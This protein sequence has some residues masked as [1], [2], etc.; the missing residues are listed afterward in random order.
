MNAKPKPKAAVAD[1]SSLTPALESAA[2][3][4]TQDSLAQHQRLMDNYTEIARL[5]G[6]LAHEIKNPLS[7]I[8]LNME[9]LAEDFADSDSPRDKRALKKISIV[10]REC[11]RLQ[12]LLDDFLRF[13]KVRPLRPVNAD[14]NR[15]V[16][17][18]IDFFRPQAQEAK[19]EIVCYLD[20]NLPA[21]R[22]DTEAFH[23]ALLNLLL[24]AQQ[25][26]PDGGQLVARTKCLD[27]QVSLDLIDTG[28]GIEPKTI[29]HIFDAF[30]STKPGGSGLG[31]PTARKVIESHGG[32]IAV[33]SELGKGTK[34]T[35]TLPAAG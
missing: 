26:M 16:Q 21:V 7:T 11:V 14:L 20:P 22:L 15:E 1:T 13:A 34:F 19:I 25:A 31:L 4:S 2:T 9:L 30:Y 27:G 29:E 12:H 18:V 33:D 23:G 28:L 3:R 35:I 10:E 17:R 6:A 24:N 32:T 5:A 8:R